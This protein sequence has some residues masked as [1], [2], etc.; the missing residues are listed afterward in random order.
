MGIENRYGYQTRFVK[1]GYDGRRPV[2]IWTNELVYVPDE[3]S[4]ESDLWRPL[5]PIDQTPYVPPPTIDI[6]V[7]GCFK[8]IW[9]YIRDEY[10][11]PICEGI[12]ILGWLVGAIVYVIG[13][14]VYKVL[15]LSY[16][17]IRKLFS[18]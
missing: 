15:H 10:I 9:E 2:Q 6:D 3:S 18:L 17:G 8:G 13:W 1:Y 4:S 14:C 5:P 12:F 11:A 7:G 16:K